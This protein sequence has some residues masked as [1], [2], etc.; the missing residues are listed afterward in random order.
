MLLIIQSQ[1][2]NPR[3][4]TEFFGNKLF[5][6]IYS[7]EFKQVKSKKGGSKVLQIVTISQDLGG[8]KETVTL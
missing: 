7:V 4:V 5:D 2:S 8:A 1:G 3:A 6:A